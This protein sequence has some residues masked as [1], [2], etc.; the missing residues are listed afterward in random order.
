MTDKEL[1]FDHMGHSEAMSKD[2]Y[3]CPAGVK[4]LNTMGKMLGHMDTCNYHCLFVKKYICLRWCITAFYIQVVFIDQDVAMSYRRFMMPESKPRRQPL[5]TA[6]LWRIYGKG[7]SLGRDPRDG[8]ILL[9]VCSS[10][11]IQCLHGDV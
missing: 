7:G 4:E 10:L 5:M 2:N 11:V 1:F 3:Q 9:S 6:N 8:E